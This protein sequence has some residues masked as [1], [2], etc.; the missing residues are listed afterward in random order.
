MGVTTNGLTQKQTADLERKLE[1]M[2]K[3]TRRYS[4]SLPSVSHANEED[5][6]DAAVETSALETAIQTTNVNNRLLSQITAA[7]ERINQGTYG[8]C[9]GCEK[10][11]GHYRLNVLPYASYCMPCQQK[12]ESPGISHLYG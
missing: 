11:I 9:H 1:G 5:P 3:K 10:P 6:S 2:L 7:L 4:G 8:A 12:R